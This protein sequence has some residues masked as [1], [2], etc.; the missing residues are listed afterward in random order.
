MPLPPK[1]IDDF[2]I[3]PKHIGLLFPHTTITSTSSAYVTLQA[4]LSTVGGS[5]NSHSSLSALEMD[6]GEIFELTS[7]AS[8]T[9]ETFL[10]TYLQAAEPSKKLVASRRM[11]N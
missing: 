11:Q 6:Y 1:Y 8:I 3:S 5:Q 2:Q 7:L 10:D 9:G 4:V